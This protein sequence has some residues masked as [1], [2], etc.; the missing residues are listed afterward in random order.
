MRW[1]LRRTITK[2]EDKACC[3]LGIFDV[4]MYP[5]YDKD[6]HAFDCLKDKIGKLHRARMDT[7]TLDCGNTSRHLDDLI[8]AASDTMTLQERRGMLLA[9]LSFDQM[10]SRRATIKNAYASTCEWLLGNQIYR[11]RIKPHNFHDHHGFL[12][13]WGKAGVGKSTLMKFAHAYTEKRKSE[14][15]IVISFFFNARGEQVEKQ[16]TGMCRSLL[17]QLLQKAVDL[18]DVLDNV[19]PTSQ[20]ESQPPQWEIEQQCELLIAALA[21]LKDRRLQCFVDALDE[22]DENQVREM[23]NVFEDLGER[24]AEKGTQIYVMFASR[25][26]QASML[27]M[28]NDWLLKTKEVTLGTWRSMCGAI[29]ALVQES[30]LRRPDQRS[31]SS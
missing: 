18:Q 8:T 13:I 28:V 16:T 14:N 7:I 11:N 19:P 9:S 2:R 26:I 17:F 30:L 4:F 15:D 1:T 29:S 5:I 21:R 6:D 31:V 12:W 23:I 22:C 3:L 20:Q 25:L 24:A 27:L 10:D